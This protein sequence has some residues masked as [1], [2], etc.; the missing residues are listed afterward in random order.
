MLKTRAVTVGLFAALACGPIALVA[1]LANQTSPEP[2][3]AQR[4]SEGAGS[5][6]GEY[7]VQVVEAWLTATEGD[8]SDLERLYPAVPAALPATPMHVRD[9]APAQIQ[10]AGEGAWIVLV[11]ADVADPA[12][13]GWQVSWI[14]RYYEVP[15]QAAETAYGTG[16]VASA[17]P[18]PVAAPVRLNDTSEDLGGTL[19][20]S[21]ELGDSITGFLTAYLTGTGPIDRYTSPETVLAPIAPAPYEAVSLTALTARDDVTDPD[22]PAE[23]QQAAVVAEVEL[24]R[25]DGETV[26]SQYHLTLTAR[27]GRWEVTRTNHDA[28]SRPQPA[29]TTE[30]DN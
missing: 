6:A 21:G 26:T 20:V 8:D 16:L 18:A 4:S 5:L 28:T 11:G 22:E 27:A 9:A 1:A 19:S 15:V 12:K 3:Q 13:D 14:R 25:T 10:P 23:G 30:G 7:A 29:G 17:L 24:T 2:V